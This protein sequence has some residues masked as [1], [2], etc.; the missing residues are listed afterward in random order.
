MEFQAGASRVGEDRVHAL[1]LK[2]PDG[3][4]M[5][6]LAREAGRRGLPTY[7]VRD[8]GRTQVAAGSQTVLAI[9]PGPEDVIDEVTGEL[10]LL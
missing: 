10:K 3:E 7:V 6:A 8:A 9:G 4:V 2:C 5:A 1:A